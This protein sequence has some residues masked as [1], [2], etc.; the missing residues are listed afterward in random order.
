MTQAELKEVGFRWT[1]PT[2]ERTAD[3]SW[4]LIVPSTLLKERETGRRTDPQFD[5]CQRLYEIYEF[6]GSWLDQLHEAQVERMLK[7]P[8]WRAELRPAGV[9]R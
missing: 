1:R 6:D 7:N 2:W 3:R 4:V 5:R 8:G 9:R